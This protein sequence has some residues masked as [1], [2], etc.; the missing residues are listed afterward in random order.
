M[1][2][3]DYRCNI[4]GYIQE[5]WI[6]EVNKNFPEFIVCRKCSGTSSRIFSPLHNICH[7]GTVGN[8]K[9]GYQSSHCGIGVK[10][11]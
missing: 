2:R 1:K 5:I 6:T 10:K 4:C 3:A 7:Q 8:S 11:T 9:N